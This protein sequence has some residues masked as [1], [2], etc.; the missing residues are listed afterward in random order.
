MRPSRPWE[1]CSICHRLHGQGYA[2]GPGLESDV[3]R[4]KKALL[5]DVLNPN[6]AIDPKFQVYVVR[7]ATQEVSGI[8]AAENSTSITLRAAMGVDTVIARRDIV[9]M[10]AYPSSMMPEGLESNLTPQDLADL[11][12]FLSTPKAVP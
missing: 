4:D 3:G 12:Q 5:T 7:T 9:D 8:V 6:R 11:L 1:S 10:K 2:V